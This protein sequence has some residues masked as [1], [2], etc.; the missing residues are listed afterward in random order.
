MGPPCVDD[1]DALKLAGVAVAGDV[2]QRREQLDLLFTASATNQE[3]K[4]RREEKSGETF[5]C[6]R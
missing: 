4:R 5:V 6:T 2:E 1:V 3:Q